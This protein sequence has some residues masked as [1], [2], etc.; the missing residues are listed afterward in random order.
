MVSTEAR[1]RDVMAHMH[2]PLGGVLCLDFANTLEPRGGPPPIEVPP[3][4]DLRDELTSYDDLVGWAAHKGAL[5]AEEGARLLAA[6]GMD[7]DGARL[8]LTRA[9]ALRDVVY[10]AFWAISQGESPAEEDLAD[11]MREYADATAHG[12]L[13][14]TGDGIDWRWPESGEVLARPL[15]PV[16]RSAVDLLASGERHRI[17][18][19]PGP[20][21]PPLSCAWLFLDTTRNASRRWCSMSDCGAATKIRLQTERRRAARG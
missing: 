2:E 12:R 10:R 14:D 5:S 7:P 20:G 6:A 18:V 13:V 15:W 1:L 8:A 21:R 19:C 3:E 4:V 17:K 9:H 16:A 11:I